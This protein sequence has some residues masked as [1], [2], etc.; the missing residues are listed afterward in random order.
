LALA[1][2]NEAALLMRVTPRHERAG[3]LADEPSINAA[4]RRPRSEAESE[5]ERRAATATNIDP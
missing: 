2:R 1:L 4:H 5:S 3:D